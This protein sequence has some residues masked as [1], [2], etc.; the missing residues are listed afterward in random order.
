M[1]VN[2]FK[3]TRLILLLIGIFLV[4]GCDKDSGTSPVPL[5]SFTL[6]Y[7]VTGGLA[8]I[9]ETFHI[10]RDSTAFFLSHYYDSTFM[11]NPD[12][13]NSLILVI[14]E[15]NFFSLEDEYFSD[16]VSDD[17]YYEISIYTAGIG[18]KAVHTS[19][20]SDKPIEL[21]NIISALANLIE[22]KKG[23]INCGLVKITKY[24]L[25]EEWPFTQS[26]RLSNYLNQD[27]D[28]G[29]TLFNHFKEY[30]QEEKEVLYFEDEWIYVLAG[31]GGYH[32]SY[33]DAGVFTVSV[34]E[35]TKPIEWLQNTGKNLQDFPDDGFLLQ[36]H[37]YFTIKEEL[38]LNQNP[39]YFIDGTLETGSYVYEIKL[40]HGNNEVNKN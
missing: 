37:D 26:Y 40:I 1:K 3:K 13:M 30:Y 20:A 28:A 12:E 5:S 16:P 27:F 29:E 19:G 7:R 14:K 2:I 31:S 35:R 18:K 39:L 36:D 10:D 11:I 21:E 24:H 15:N 4:S 8:G 32:L 25:L 22:I 6:H 33:Q 34:S 9:S 23:N 38:E 17:I